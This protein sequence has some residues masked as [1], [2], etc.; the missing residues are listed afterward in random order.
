MMNRS[1]NLL[2]TLVTTAM[3]FVLA[4][5]VLA[6]VTPTPPTATPATATPAT[7]TPPT[8]VPTP[9]PEPTCTDRW[10]ISTAFTRA[11]GQSTGHFSNN[12]N[13]LIF[14]AI[15]GHIIQPG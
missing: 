14:H 10:P 7:A 13:S 5:P 11:K 3:V 15:T 9:T 1:T 2:C 6:G 12:V 4:T 8:V